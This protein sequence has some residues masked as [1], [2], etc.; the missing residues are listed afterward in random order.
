MSA[1][2]LFIRSLKSPWIWA[3]ALLSIVPPDALSSAM[4]WD[5]VDPG[6]LGA[7]VLWWPMDTLLTLSVLAWMLKLSQ[8][9]RPQRKP[10]AAL[11][12]AVNAEALLSLRAGIVALLGLIPA[13]TV[14]AIGGV[15]RAWMRVVLGFLVVAGLGPAFTYFLRRSLAPVG[16]LFHPLSGAE[17]LDWSRDRLR[18]QLWRFLKLAGPWWLLGWALDGL[19]LL[20]GQGDSLVLQSLT[21]L[22]GVPSLVSALLPLAIF[23]AP[24]ETL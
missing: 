23:V 22:L 21:W 7:S 20:L 19:N 12:A 5:I 10:L 24:D 14:L 16:L 15:D 9:K 18:G 4:G 11:P 2:R 13:L 6:Y 17:A 3:L 1:R 8:A